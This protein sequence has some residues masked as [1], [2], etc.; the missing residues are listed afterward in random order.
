MLLDSHLVEKFHSLH[1][2]RMSGLL[3]ASGDGF[4]LGICLSEGDPVA[5][6]LGE[7][8][9]RGFSEACRIYHKLDDA[10]LAELQAATAGG[11]KAR[12]YLVQHQLISDAEADQLSQA[13]VEDALTRGF[14]GPCTSI[15]FR[16]GHTV[17][18]LPIGTTALKMRIGVEALIRTCDAR[19]GEQQAV[20]REIG[21]WEA[22][23]ALTEGEHV[24]GQLSE[25]EKMVLNFIDGRSTVEQI[26]ELC[27]DSSLN[28]GRVLRSLI[29]KRVIHRIDQHRTSGVRP[30]VGG[31][32]VPA[33][34]TRPAVASASSTP[35]IDITPYRA[36]PEPSSRPVVMIG[37]IALLVISLGV[38]LLVVQYNR[39]QDRLRKDEV[40]INQLLGE[41][42]WQDAR[43][44]ITQLRQQAGNDLGAIRQVDGLGGQVEAA[45]TAER[46][47]IAELI[48]SEDF[49]AA[50][51][52]LVSLPEDGGLAQR[53]RDAENELRV[54][55]ESVANEVQARLATGDVAGALAAIDAVSGRRAVEAE[56]VLAQWRSDAM[57]IAKSQ[58]QPLQQRIAALARLRQARPDAQIETQAVAL[59]GELQGQM[60]VISDRLVVL[61]RQAEAGA[62]REVRAE[63]AQQRLGELGVG[64]DIEARVTR[65]HAA[66]ATSEQR[67]HAA[68]QPALASLARGDGTDE[69]ESARAALATMLQALPQASDRA[70]IDRLSGALA[71]C[72]G[73]GSRTAAER[74]SEAE[75]LAVQIPESEPELAQALRERAA[76]MRS[77]ET[78]A[79]L[80]LDEARRLGRIGDW[81]GSVAALEAI[82]RQP[83]WQL[84]AVRKEA[85]EELD[86]ARAR[87]VR[88]DQ[89]KKELQSALTRGDMVACETIAREIGLAY[90]PLVINSAPEG[91]EVL[92]ADGRV[93]GVTPLIQEVTADER[94]EF[95]LRLRK[96]GYREVELAGDKA[97]G[98]WRLSARLERIPALVAAVGHPLTARPSVVDGVLWLAD[99]AHTVEL[100]GLAEADRRSV[101][102]QSVAVLADPVV[103]PVTRVGGSLLL[104]T[105]ERLAV[106]L[107]GGGGR[108]S[109]PA[110]TDHHLL[111]YRSPLVLDRELLIVAGND[112]RLHAVDQGTSRPLWQGGTGAAF[113]C[114]PI[115][116]GD[117]ILA[118]RTD[119]RLDAVRVEDGVTTS[120]SIGEPVVSAWSD[121]PLLGGLTAGRSW[122]W[123]GAVLR[124]QDLP[125]PCIGGGRGIAVGAFGRVHLQDGET[126]RDVGRLDPRPQAGEPVRAIS[127]AGHAVITVGRVAHTLGAQ[128]F[129]LDAGSEL[130]PPVIWDG[131]LV[132]ASLE[133]GIWVYQP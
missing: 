74:A 48:A 31:A 22:V 28:L 32:P 131:R 129:R 128:P 93:L 110:P 80:S 82:V 39:K 17:E 1:R 52:R 62:W 33:S 9:E 11:I 124:R 99:R 95:R 6:D 90:L 123:D 132:L 79:R 60:R 75:A 83:S 24:S 106:R 96:A 18:Q 117:L 108:L 38:A 105:R 14:R 88:R 102:I 43:S 113:A 104:A 40:E 122:T 2:Q 68:V 20:E 64:N 8:L 133:G 94:V 12:D 58:N 27:R 10:G 125:E 46:T 23:F 3:V 86:S 85:E 119:G 107:D 34:G 13:V 41:R 25:Y 53:L 54:D 5:V 26:A 65:T 21:T 100:R 92:A 16:P 77:I 47:A 37:L 4:R 89:L 78:Q 29:A 67:I 98:G 50:R 36:A 118:V 81:N 55:S 114:A 44:T 51:Q 19:V 101:S 69:L 42:K 71:A 126:W 45:I 49:S 15:E 91:A 57:V 87:A 111:S 109:L 120:V 116:A 63:L 130:L 103:A 66:A 72:A 115:L 7:D 56:R 35:P 84:T 59:E 76:S 97:E 73:A 61:E 121:G 112:G 30:A 127:W 70:A